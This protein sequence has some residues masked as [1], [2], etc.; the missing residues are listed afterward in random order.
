MTQQQGNGASY[1]LQYSTSATGAAHHSAGPDRGKR[2]AR[3]ECNSH[4]RET[5]LG[6]YHLLLENAV[7]QLGPTS[8]LQ[9]VVRPPPPA[10]PPVRIPIPTYRAGNGDRHPMQSGQSESFDNRN[11]RLRRITE[12][13]AFANRMNWAWRLGGFRETILPHERIPRCAWNGGVVSRNI[14]HEGA[15]YA[16]E[17]SRTTYDISDRTLDSYYS[18]RRAAE[19]APQFTTRDR[20]TQL[21]TLREK[22]Q[23]KRPYT[24]D[25]RRGLYQNAR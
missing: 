7:R 17:R 2:A 24:Q 15:Q 22:T 14:I 9:T 6:A 3:A 13:V 16:D 4:H 20:N 5:T 19:I 21:P 23:P 25:E 11:R 8:V 12:A 10:R 1:S 18:E